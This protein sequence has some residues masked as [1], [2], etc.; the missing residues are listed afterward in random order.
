MIHSD[1][2]STVCDAESAQLRGGRRVGRAAARNQEPIA[3]IGIGC[4]LPGGVVDCQTYWDL[5]VGGRDAITQTPPERWIWE[6]FYSPGDPKPGK[7]QSRWGGYVEDLDQFDPQLFGIS[8]REAANVDPQHRLLLET[9]YR[10]V[11]D[12]GLPV[13]QI[14]G[15]PVSVFVGI[16]SFDYAVAGMSFLDRGVLNP[17]SNTGA[18]SS[19]AANRISYSFD[20]RGPSVA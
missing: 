5:W 4:R 1:S 18:S 6:R 19:I 12:A 20:L 15:Q 9:A 17:Y 3:I 16:S 8:P 11:E 7:T 13:E 10:A 14:A 2:K